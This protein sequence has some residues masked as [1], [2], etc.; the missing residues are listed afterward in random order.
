MS[1]KLNFE[2]IKEIVAHGSKIKV[3]EIADP[4]TNAILKATGVGMVTTYIE[5]LSLLD[6]ICNP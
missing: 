4:S 6:I 1:V 5:Q 2:L 3:N